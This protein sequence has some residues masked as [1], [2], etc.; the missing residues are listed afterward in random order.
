MTI[1]AKA[2]LNT[3]HSARMS[4]SDFLS[5]GD[6]F[7]EISTAV[8]LGLRPEFGLVE[9][10][11]QFYIGHNLTSHIQ[12]CRALP[13]TDSD[14]A[15]STRSSNSTALLRLALVGPRAVAPIAA[16]NPQP[17]IAHSRQT[18]S[19]WSTRIEPKTS[20]G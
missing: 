20:S 6:V 16:D 19:R 8:D 1:A 17:A 14:F 4:R 9:L 10:L 3:L 12:E 18:L 7:G 5:T 13:F 2:L 11:H 15:G